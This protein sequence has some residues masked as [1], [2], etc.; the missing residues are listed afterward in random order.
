MPNEQPEISQPFIYAAQ[1]YRLAGAQG[2]VPLGLV[3]GN[4]KAGLKNPP[5]KGYTGAGGKYVTELKLANWLNEDHEDYVGNANIGLRLGDVN[6]DMRGDLPIMYNGQIVDGWENIGID[7]DTYGSKNGSKQLDKL[8]AQYGKLPPTIRSSSRW[9][10]GNLSYIAV[11]LVPKGYRFIGKAAGC[12]EIVQKRHRY[13]CVWP[14]TNPDA[15][16]ARYEWRDVDDSSLFTPRLDGATVLPE[17][18]FRYL[19]NNGV[20]DTEDPISDL[21]GDELLGWAAETWKDHAGEPCQEMQDSADRAIFE[22]ED[23]HD[24]HPRLTKHHWRILRLGAEGHGGWLSALQKVNECWIRSAGSKRDATEGMSEEIRRSVLGALGKIEPN[25]DQLLEDPCITKRDV[26]EG[27]YDDRLDNWSAQEACACGLP[28][29]TGC[30]K[31]KQITANDFGGLGPVVGRLQAMKDNP[32]DAYGQ[33]DEGNGQHFVDLYGANVKFVDGR[34]DWTLWVSAD[35]DDDNGRWYADSGGKFIS[36]AYQRVRKRQESFARNAAMEAAK[37]PQ[38]TLLKKRAS[39][40]LSWAKRSGDVNPI[41]NAIESSKRLY[42]DDNTPVTLLGEEFD[43]NPKLLGCANGVLELT[44]DPELRPPRREDYVTYN[45]GTPYIPWRTLAMSDDA[46]LDGFHLWQEYLNLFLP[47]PEVR[48]FVHKVMGHTLIGENPEKLLVFLYGSHDTG[49][50]TMIGAIAGALGQYYG[51]IDMNLFKQ[52]DLNPQLIRAVP[53]RVTGMS[54]VDAG[55]MDAATIK[56]LTGNDTV[57]AEAKYSNKIFQ[58]RPQFTTLIACNNP[59]NINNADEALRERILALPFSTTIDRAHRKYE[60]Q[61]EIEKYSNIS[62]LSWLVEGWRLYCE[63]GIKRSTWPRQVKSL[64]HE[65]VSGFNPTQSFFEQMIIKARDSRA[66]IMAENEAVTRA[67]KRGKDAPSAVDWDPVWT[68][69]A[70]RMYE[71]YV[72]WSAA[73]GVQPMSHPQFSKELCVGR[74]VQ[75]KLDGNN[76]RVYVGVKIRDE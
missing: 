75:R 48:H 15:K 14:S 53:L 5:P 16:G 50:S 23:A 49:K 26:A 12:I 64:H 43:A 25:F 27:K 58:G 6:V 69:I 33:H 60:R 74:P 71:M 39:S 11:F 32:A 7:V 66:G 76:I 63:E 54:E 8:Q 55:V 17:E 65:V 37:N 4:W 20:L 56:R 51:T 47:D 42:V 52:K 41:R 22:I 10:S 57:I 72:R 19:S 73:N 61:T 13:M 68:P 59:P 18:W 62:V 28:D 29:C 45:T 70:S 67:L 46:N 44:D 2:V 24:S 34:D 9:G 1:K 40:W 21:T 31:G 36:L 30:E 35:G 38:N 3:E